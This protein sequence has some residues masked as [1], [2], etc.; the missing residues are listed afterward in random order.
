MMITQ[1]FMDTI[2]AS[3]VETGQSVLARQV[4]AIIGNTGSLDVAALY[5]GV[6]RNGKAVNPSSWLN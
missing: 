3:K 2:K 6:T 5:F 4:I 1:L